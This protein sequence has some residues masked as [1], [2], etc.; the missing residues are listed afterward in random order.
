MK[1]VCGSLG[2]SYETAS[3]L[4]IVVIL[5]LDAKPDLKLISYNGKLCRNRRRFV[6]AMASRGNK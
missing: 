2:Y 5:V 3:I 6:I 4:Y 1:Q